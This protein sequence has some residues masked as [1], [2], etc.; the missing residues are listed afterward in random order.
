[1]LG[2]AP[3]TDGASVDCEDDPESD[4][5]GELSWTAEA[6]ESSKESSAF[7]TS[8]GSTRCCASR[9]G[10]KSGVASSKPACGK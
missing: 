1:M 7:G 2:T 5:V 6:N 9:L 10:V 3:G 4:C 8:G